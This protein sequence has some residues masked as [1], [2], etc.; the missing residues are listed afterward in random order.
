MHAVRKHRGVTLI[1]CMVLLLV[2]TV[3][4]VAG[5]SSAGTEMAMAGNEQYR[6]SAF[7]AAESGI[8]QALRRAAFDPDAA[9]GQGFAGAVRNNSDNAYTSQV[10][11]RGQSQGYFLF[12]N[13]D[14]TTYYFDIRSTGISQRN[15]TAT[16][17]Q[18]VALPSQTDNTIGCIG[19]APPPCTLN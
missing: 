13:S 4:A 1:I 10:Q 7:N 15:S 16:H 9:A 17:V 11:P 3:L 2:L 19:G 5:L 18:G 14:F 12:S 6:Q 8:A